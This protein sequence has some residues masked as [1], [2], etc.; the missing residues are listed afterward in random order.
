MQRI[1][2]EFRQFK[3]AMRGYDTQEVD[4]YIESLVDYCDTLK[5]SIS[6]LKK[7]LSVYEAQENLIKETLKTAEQTAATIK[8]D[9]QKMAKNLQ[10]QA[11]KKALDL[12]KNAEQETKTYNSNKYSRFFSYERE[13]RLVID[14]FYVYARKHMEQ[15]AQELNQDINNTISGLDVKQDNVPK[16]IRASEFE[17]D[18]PDASKISDRLKELESAALIGRVLKHD[19]V[20]AEGYILVEKDTII[21]PELISSFITKGLYGELIASAEKEK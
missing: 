17:S 10:L 9:A 21:T 18:I 19:I 6:S 1:D 12:I 20:N 11:E 13:L 14:R 3:K 7:R 4:A 5:S 8:E 2:F 16:K 15:L